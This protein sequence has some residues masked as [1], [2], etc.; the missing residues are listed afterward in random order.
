MSDN[1]KASWE[2]DKLDMSSAMRAILIGFASLLSLSALPIAA[3]AQSA[4]APAVAPVLWDKAA[5]RALLDFG[6]RIGGDGLNPADYRL[7]ALDQA[8]AGG[9]PAELDSAATRSF[10]LLA[11]DLADGHVPPSARKDS[12]FRYPT[13]SPAGIEQM[14]ELALST[15][16]VAASLA[17]LLPTSEDY[18]ALKAALAATPAADAERRRTL[19]VNLDRWRWLPRDLGTRYLLVD[20][21]AYEVRL[22]DHGQ[23]IETHRVIVG[24]LKTVTPEFAAKVTGVLINP[25]WTVPDSIIRESVGKLVRTRPSTASARGYTWFTDAAG[26]LHVVQ[27]PGANNALGQI[28]LV[29]PNPYTIYL[30]D[31]PSKSLFEKSVRA[32]SHG[33]I[34]TDKPAALAARL[35]E[36]TGWDEAR[37]NAQ[38]EDGEPMTVSLSRPI[39]IVVAYLTA[40]PGPDGTISFYKDIYGRDDAVAAALGADVAPVGDVARAAPPRDETCAVG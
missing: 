16:T 20:V 7:A 8:I 9:S 29:M 3:S 39:P 15:R 34:R 38:I 35:L 27:K 19:R 13:L 31:T 14:M 40:A 6:Q 28:K 24:K 30:H 11:H 21:P 23:V 17:G 26:K 10:A 4:P 25:D 1:A 5:A 32:Y 18:R 2:K 37:I 22:V 33:C 36:G 12:H